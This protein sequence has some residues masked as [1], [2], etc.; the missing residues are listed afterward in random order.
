MQGTAVDIDRDMHE[1]QIII[2]ILQ[3]RSLK[4]HQNPHLWKLKGVMSFHLFVHNE[5]LFNLLEFLTQYIR[6]HDLPSPS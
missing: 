2:L 6:R 1:G 4:L 3:N 5:I